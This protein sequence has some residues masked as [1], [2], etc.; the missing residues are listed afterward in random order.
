MAGRE[1]ATA[2]RILSPGGEE[3]PPVV[4]PDDDEE[5]EDI[6][7]VIAQVED[8]AATVQI[9]RWNPT[10]EDPGKPWDYITTVA[11]KEFSLETIK[12]LYGGGKYKAVTLDR[13]RRYVKGGS[14]TFTIDRM[15][16]PVPPPPPPADPAGFAGMAP[17]L[18][19]EIT[20]LMAKVEQ[21]AALLQAR[22]GTKE[23]LD[24]ALKIAAVFRGAGGGGGGITPDTVFNI[25][26][27]GLDFSRR[28]A[29]GEGEGGAGEGEDTDAFGVALKELVKPVAR[30]LET[31]VERR[32]RIRPAPA[33]SRVPAAPGA[34]GA[35]PPPGDPA[36]AARLAMA[37]DWLRR[38]QPWIPQLLGLAR[39]GADPVLYA[40]VVYD[41]LTRK[42]PE[43][44]L[45]AVEEA[46]KR[47]D[48]VA[49][50]LAALPKPCEP[51]REWFAVLLGSLKATLVE[52]PEGEEPSPA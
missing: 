12:R 16:K 51:F 28:L 4:E 5:L 11:A 9:K 6:E 48:F 41:L 3:A 17:R 49:T 15:F 52:P 47:D 37:P 46:A 14:H 38:V 10:P 22:D 31:E 7:G 18:A 34:T 50:V 40:D 27:K 33:P 20:A 42:L 45:A 35:Q 1:R 29:P 24:M 25:F 21:L 2:A 39:E 8:G 23:T 44:Q 32:A 43:A 36:E 19:P 13:N 30:L 26:E